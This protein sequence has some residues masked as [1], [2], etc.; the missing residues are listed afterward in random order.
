M[1]R[2]AYDITLYL[3]ALTVYARLIPIHWNCGTVAVCDQPRTTLYFSLSQPFIYTSF[4][5][6]F[7]FSLRSTLTHTQNSIFSC[8]IF[9]YMIFSLFRVRGMASFCLLS[10]DFHQQSVCARLMVLFSVPPPVNC[11]PFESA[12][13]QTA[14][15]SILSFVNEP[16]DSMCTLFVKV[17][18]SEFGVNVYV[19]FLSSSLTLSRPHNM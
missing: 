16:R 18:L 7:F 19:L 5:L 11:I 3:C 4:S 1:P 6:F 15:V 12:S 2:Y 8:Y 13:P 14:N 17:T 9:Y 10:L